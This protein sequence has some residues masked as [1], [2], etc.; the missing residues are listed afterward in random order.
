MWVLGFL[1]L[2]V[3][4]AIAVLDLSVRMPAEGGLYVWTKT[5]FGDAHGFIAGWTYWISNIV[6]FPATLLFGAGVFLY[7]GGAGWIAHAADPFYNAAFGLIVLWGGTMLNV[8]GLERAKWVQ[9]IGGVATWIGAAMIVGAG[10]WAY[11]RFGSAT[12]IT[13]SNV[14]PDF[15]GLPTLA[16]FATIA[17][18]YVGLEL[19]PIVG[20]EIRDPRRS[21]PRAVLISGV[22]VAAIYIVGTLSLL[23]ALP[24][25]TIDVIAGIPQALTAIG[26]RIGVPGFGRV[27][28]LA[29]AIG[30]VGSVSA[31]ITCTARLPFV[32]G[33]D[34]YL[35]RAMSRLHPRF[36]TPHV[37]LIVQASLTTLILG[38]ALSGSTIHEAFALLIDMMVILGLLPL[39][40]LF[41]AYPVLRRRSSAR[42]ATTRLSDA[43]VWLAAAMGLATTLIA[44]VMSV[45]PPVDSASP[46]LFIAKVIGGTVLMVGVGLVFYVRGRRGLATSASN[47]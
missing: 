8:G 7:V 3:P 44:V 29:V 25:A 35:P 10:A 46:S 42:D 47:R 13:A 27:A 20:G 6:Y 19:G 31:W 17:F 26:E 37:A 21:I 34:R 4:L 39:L 14:W 40:Y 18:A 22:I 33:V 38:A 43:G 23:V 24:V 1:G 28:A 36:G 12:P 2:F 16:T 11:V 9:N 45:I 41:A 32:V 5:A 15:A 30:S